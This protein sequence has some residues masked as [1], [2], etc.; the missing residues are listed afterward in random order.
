MNLSESPVGDKALKHPRPRLIKPSMESL[1]LNKI[2]LFRKEIKLC[3]ENLLE[4]S[5]YRKDTIM[6]MLTMIDLC[7]DLLCIIRDNYT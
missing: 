6:K 3:D 4:D 1:L 2:E 5:Q 7:N